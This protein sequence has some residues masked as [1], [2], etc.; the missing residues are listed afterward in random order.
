MATNDRQSSQGD[1]PAG[2]TCSHYDAIPGQKHCR[3]YLNNGACSKPDE[4]MCREW[5]K[6][7][8]CDVSLLERIAAVTAN[9]A[10]D[11]H[12]ELLA[13]SPVDLFGFPNPHY[14][15]ELAESTESARSN[16]VGRENP[17]ETRRGH[18]GTGSVPSPAAPASSDVAETT[19]GP[20]L[21]GLTTEDIAS[22]KALRADVCFDSEAFGEVWLVPEYTGRDR[23]EITP[24]HAATICRVIDAFPGSRL[25]SFEKPPK[26]DEE[27]K[28]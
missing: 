15:P 16:S 4:F 11:A 6:V 27:T 9:K 8:G 21:R 13:S 17:S 1:R 2:I 10:Q 7:N 28:S 14:R 25:V 24:E 26:S 22:F 23:K 19:E 12:R 3:H 18:S 20:P 5:L